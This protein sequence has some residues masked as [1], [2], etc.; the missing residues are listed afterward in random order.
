M[1]PLD[2]QTRDELRALLD[3]YFRQL[4]PLL[5]NNEVAGHH[6]MERVDLAEDV[7]RKMKD[8]LNRDRPR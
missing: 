1:R 8:V 3:D 6:T 7:I 4:S 2:E 5:Q